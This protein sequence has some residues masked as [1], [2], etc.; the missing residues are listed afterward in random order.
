[1]YFSLRV[2]TFYNLASSAKHFCLYEPCNPILI[3]TCYSERNTRTASVAMFRTRDTTVVMS[4][5]I[6]Q[7]KADIDVRAF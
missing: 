5:I 2:V 3:Y 6:P 7:E 1:M 4:P